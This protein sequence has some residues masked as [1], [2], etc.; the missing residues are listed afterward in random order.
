LN[1]QNPALTSFAYTY[2]NNECQGNFQPT[3][4]GYGWF[5][6][7]FFEH[8]TIILRTGIQNKDNKMIW[9]QSIQLGESVWP[10]DLIQALGEGLEKIGVSSNQP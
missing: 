5:K 7:F 3:E 8:S 6:V 9:V 4:K 10:H 2:H 1:A